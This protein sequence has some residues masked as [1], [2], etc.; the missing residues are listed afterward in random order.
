MLST[1]LNSYFLLP[2]LFILFIFGVIILTFCI[3]IYIFFISKK[4]KN[5]FNKKD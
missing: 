4:I 3:I 2:H 5:K 1:A